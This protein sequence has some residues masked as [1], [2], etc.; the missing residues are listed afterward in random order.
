MNNIT[1]T[2]EAFGLDRVE[3]RPLSGDATLSRADLERNAAT[4]ENV[5]LWNDQPLLDTFGQMQEI[6]TYYDFARRRQ[7]PLHHQRQVPPDHALGA[8]AE[9]AQPAEPHVD[10]RAAD[11]HAR[12]RADARPRQRGHAG[13]AA[14]ALHPRPAAELDRRL[15]SD[16]TGDLL[17]RAAG[18]RRLRQHQDRRVRL[19]ARRRQRLCDLQRQRR[20][21]ARRALPPPDVRD[22]VPLDRH[23]LL[24]DADAGEP[25]DDA[26]A[27]Q[28]AREQDCARS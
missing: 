3:E 13:R 19:S 28:R 15:E 22:P 24:P 9:L 11:V 5:P 6:R 2:R 10:Q 17:W 1:A 14:G 23:V 7:R 8:R 27:H 4:I 26:P 18:D 12:L 25:R 20:R 21:A 16:A